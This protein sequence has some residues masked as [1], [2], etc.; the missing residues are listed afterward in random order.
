MT[1]VDGRELRRDA[2]FDADVVI[3]GSGP[4]G[5]AV[6]RVVSASG[7]SVIV[8]EAGPWLE[9]AD[10]ALS[11]FSAMSATYRDL[12][13]SVA[14]A[15]SVGLGVSVGGTGVIAASCATAVLVA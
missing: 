5:A 12:G 3:V 9:P 11:A 7:A 10:F 1:R 4:A 15:A 14:V 13:G 8:L 6:A 2:T